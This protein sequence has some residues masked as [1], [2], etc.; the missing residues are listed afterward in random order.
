M[1]APDHN[2]RAVIFPGSSLGNFQM[3]THS[4]GVASNQNPN[5]WRRQV[6]QFETAPE[7]TVQIAPV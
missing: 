1:V 7:F 5:H 4:M 3:L 6:G 2:D